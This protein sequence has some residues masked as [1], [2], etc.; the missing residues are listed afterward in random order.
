MIIQVV[1]EALHKLRNAEAGNFSGLP[2]TIIFY[3]LLFLRKCDLLIQPAYGSLT[4]ETQ[5]G[6]WYPY[7]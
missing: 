6:E 5:T 7:Q 4:L 1:V 3:R 2:I